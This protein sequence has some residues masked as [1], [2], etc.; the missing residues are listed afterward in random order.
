MPDES[1]LVYRSRSH[2]SVGDRSNSA[3][4]DEFAI[5]TRCTAAVP[6]CSISLS[7]VLAEGRSSIAIATVAYASVISTADDRAH[8]L[9]SDY[10]HGRL[11]SPPERAEHPIPA[12][13]SLDSAFSGT[14]LTVYEQLA[15]HVAQV[16]SPAPNTG[17]YFFFGG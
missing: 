9:L 13:L 15:D 4:I 10:A 5:V 14:T 11:L 16:M 1:E 3:F 2:I 12:L 17:P 8:L 6:S 7:A